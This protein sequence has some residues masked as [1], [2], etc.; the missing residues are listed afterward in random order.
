MHPPHKENQEC[1]FCSTQHTIMYIAKMPPIW[2]ASSL[3]LNYIDV[4]TSEE[5][6]PYCPL[7][8]I[9]NLE[10]HARLLN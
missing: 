6:V 9:G 4:F 8:R 1:T 7:L 2:G 5:V 3:A 10:F